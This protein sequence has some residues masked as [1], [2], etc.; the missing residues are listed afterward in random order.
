MKTLVVG[1]QD[2]V[3]RVGTEIDHALDVTFVDLQP[4]ATLAPYLKDTEILL[5]SPQLRV[6]DALLDAAPKLRLIQV[7]STG[8]DKIDTEAARRRSIPVAHSGGTN[9]LSVAEHVYMVAMALIKRL[10][11]NHLGIGQGQYVQNKARLM[12]E[13]LGELH[14]K[15]LGIVGFGRIGRQVALRAIP[16]GLNTVYYDIVRASPEDEAKY[17]VTYVERPELLRRADILTVHVPLMPSTHHLIGEAELAQLKPAAIVINAARGP[18]VDPA[19]LAAMVADGMLAGAA[20][21]VF[22]TEPAPETDPLVA[23][24]MSGCERIIVTTH[25]AGVT[26]EANIRGLQMAFNNAALRAKG[27]P[28]HAVVNDVREGVASFSS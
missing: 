11:P 2:R 14:G 27:Q 3:E 18:V 28:I 15:T 4:L 1:L 22:E 19:P 25:M 10:I 12:N 7:P 26:F 17:Q 13:G 9:A 21:D 16:F 23:L 6:D 24:A 5:T 8:Y 20:V